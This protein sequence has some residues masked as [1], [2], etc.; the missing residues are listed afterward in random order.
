MRLFTIVPVAVFWGNVLASPERHWNVNMSEPTPAPLGNA[1]FRHPDATIQI[2]IGDLTGSAVINLTHVEA[3]PSFTITP[4]TTP[5]GANATGL[6]LN[7][8]GTITT[9]AFPNPTGFGTINLT[10]TFNATTQSTFRSLVAP[11][12]ANDNVSAF[13]GGAVPSQPE[14]AYLFAVICVIFGVWC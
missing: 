13:T 9:G 6:W 2:Q 8:S 4:L 1:S 14:A 3:T 12:S 7:T 10:S 5:L 11:T